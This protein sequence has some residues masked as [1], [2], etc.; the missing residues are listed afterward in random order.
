V[1]R[2]EEKPW[3]TLLTCQGYDANKNTYLY[4]IAVRATLLRVEAES[5]PNSRNS[6]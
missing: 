5:T 6:R 2:H 1:F 3:L 4:R